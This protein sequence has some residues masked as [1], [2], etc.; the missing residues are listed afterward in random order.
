MYVGDE[1]NS[2]NVRVNINNL[3]DRV[4][5]NELRTNIAAGDGNGVLWNGV[6]TANQGYFGLGRTWNV[7]L[8][9]RF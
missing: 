6:D 3:L 4:Y 5:I 9:Y 7:G 1:G 2:L 8:R